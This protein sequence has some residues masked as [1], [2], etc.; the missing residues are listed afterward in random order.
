MN[1]RE[2]DSDRSA[3]PAEAAAIPVEER[4]NNPYPKPVRRSRDTETPLPD[5]EALT[6]PE[7]SLSDMPLTNTALFEA[8][9]LVP[10]GSSTEIPND[11]G[12]VEPAAS[13][14]R[15]AAEIESS[16]VLAQDVAATTVAPQTAS[17]PAPN[18]RA[19]IWSEDWDSWIYW[20]T[21]LQSWFRHDMQSGNW[22]ELDDA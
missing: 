17:S 13:A 20:D 8:L 9:G 10:P 16:Q 11:S 1:N 18:K 15:P 19:P 4:S 5:F 21:T 2:S 6:L 7:S 14:G 22:V 3:P 12:D